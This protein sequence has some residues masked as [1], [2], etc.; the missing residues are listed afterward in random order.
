MFDIWPT[1]LIILSFSI[2]NISFY[3]VSWGF[4][5]HIFKKISLYYQIFWGVIF[6]FISTFSIAITN[7]VR[8]PKSDLHLTLFIPIISYFIAVLFVSWYASIGILVWNTL[9]FLLFSSLFSQYFGT[10]DD[11]YTKILIIILY[12]IPFIGSVIKKYAYNKLSQWFIVSSTILVVF[13]TMLV[14]FIVEEKTYSLKLEIIN[15]LF[16]LIGIYLVYLICQTVEKIYK[17]ALK[18]QNIVVYEN[19]YYL[20]FASTNSQ[21]FDLIE[22]EKIKYGIYCNFYIPGLEKLERKVSNV[23]KDYIVSSISFNAYKSISESFKK[24]VFFKPNYKTFGVFIPI[25]IENINDMRK[26]FDVIKLFNLLKKIKTE[27]LLSNYEIKMKLKSVSSFYGLHSNDLDKLNDLNSYLIKNQLTIKNNDNSIAEPNVILSEKNR[28]RRLASLN[29][30]VNLNLHTT[31]YEPIYDLQKESYLGFFMNGMINGEEFNSQSFLKYKNQI[32]DMGLSSLFLRFICLNSL[33]DYTK[34]TLQNKT[35]GLVF[36]NYDSDYLSSAEF[37]KDGFILKMKSFKLDINNIVF[38]F[39]IDKEI[40]SKLV[41]KNN[42]MFLKS[43]KIKISVSNFG[44][45]FSDYSLLQ[46]YEPDYIFLESEIAKN[47]TN[48]DAYKKIIDEVYKISKKIEAQ[49]IVTGVNSYIIYKRLK[50]YG[51]NYFLGDLIGSSS[52]IKTKVP[53]ELNYLLKK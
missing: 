1:I 49:I 19:E 9:N 4:T 38:N 52:E 18:L 14:I 12:L 25:N 5:R 16:I 23:I 47:I 46:C 13:I 36:I 20:N 32:E 22:K 37:D 35:T 15:V 21:I 53:E 48:T 6:G 40:N 42:I 39:E 41:L 26:N 10:V 51:L 44:S 31:I 24:V 8:E 11:Q 30:V 29:E 43:L 2:I 50:E 34:K 3:L 17:H 28:N 27:F 7:I 45:E 33:K